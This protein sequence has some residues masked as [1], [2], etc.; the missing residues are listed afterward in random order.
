MS[1]RVFDSVRIVSVTNLHNCYESGDPI[2]LEHFKIVTQPKGYEEQVKISPIVADATTREINIS[3][4]V[5]MG[6]SGKSVNKVKKKVYFQLRHNGHI[7]RDSTQITII[8]ETVGDLSMQPHWYEIYRLLTQMEELEN[9]LHQKID[10]LSNSA[11]LLKIIR[12][13]SFSFN[14]ETN[15]VV[16]FRLEDVCCNNDAVSAASIELPYLS[17]SGELECSY[18]FYLPVVPGLG[19]NIG[20]GLSLGISIGPL[21]DVFTLTEGSD[22][23]YRTELPFVLYFTAS[24]TVELFYILPQLL[25]GGLTIQGD[26]AI[27]FGYDLRSRKFSRKPITISANI[28]GHITVIGFEIDACVWPLFSKTF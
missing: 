22:N 23:C 15:G 8:P 6:V 26:A 7:S 5:G 3:Y 14:H 20:L 19:A 18:P 13:C 11:G 16:N 25:S 12:G 1:V 9:E 4:G 17:V 24:G 2:L 27:P 21:S 10:T 28:R